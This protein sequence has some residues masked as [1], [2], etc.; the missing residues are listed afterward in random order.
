MQKGTGS[1]I[2][3]L[4]C[5]ARIE[6]GKK[7]WEHA[8]LVRAI[9]ELTKGIERSGRLQVLGEELVVGGAEAGDG[10]P[11]GD[12]GEALDVEDAE[13]VLVEALAGGHVLADAAQLV[14]G[15][16][17]EAEGGLAGVLALEVDAGDDR[18]EGGGGAGGAGHG[19]PDGAAA[20]GGRVV[21]LEVGAEGGH[22]GVAAAGGVEVGG[23]G[24][25]GVAGVEVR[26]DGGLLV[27]G[28]GEV[29]GEAAAGEAHGLLGLGRGVGV[30]GAD[31]RDV[32]AGGGPAGHELGA[33]EVLA[34]AGARVAGGGEDGDAA[35]AEL[36]EGAVVGL[37]LLLVLGVLE[38]A[39][40][41][42]EGDDGRGAGDGQ[43][44]VGPV[45]EVD[46]H[47]DGHVLRDPP[48]VDAAGDRGDVLEVKRALGVVG[49]AGGVGAVDVDG[50]LGEVVEAGEGRDVL[51]RED[52]LLELADAG[53]E[54]GGRG[55]GRG[56]R[57]V[58][59]KDRRGG[60]GHAG[61]GVAL[62][63]VAVHLADHADLG[64]LGLL[65]RD[66]EHAVGA[67]VDLE[68]GERLA[69]ALGVGE[70]GVL[71]GEGGEVGAGGHVAHDDVLGAEDLDG[72][73][74]VGLEELNGG[75]DVLVGGADQL[76]ELLL[77]QV[78]A[79][80]G[81]AGGGALDEGSLDLGLGVL[82]AAQVELHLD[83]LAAEGH[84]AEHGVG[85]GDQAH[86]GQGSRDE[87]GAHLCGSLGI[88]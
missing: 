33:G 17:Q 50:G 74:A 84:G 10:V 48:G 21:D 44:L 42:G 25:L 81:A 18:R 2:T 36:A 24:E 41:P 63:L 83:R 35:E 46:A 5:E 9:V 12:G 40:A 11:A 60:L 68:P 86:E 37:K 75:G 71:H 69:E 82:G 70:V 77:G 15:G 65:E 38:G 31:G 13:A 72:L 22:V 62:G 1:V 53:G 88:Q 19:A 7:G 14:D 58:A 73:G 20:R 16:V 4:G 66:G 85:D 39:E 26:R 64:G 56:G 79:E 67:D 61:E 47:R 59:G 28:G 3:R 87:S 29:V 8:L 49:G 34:R 6:K 27:R 76:D 51:L 30:G 78:L 54:V 45:G 55:G 32:G 43:H 80:Q 23:L 57:L 52:G